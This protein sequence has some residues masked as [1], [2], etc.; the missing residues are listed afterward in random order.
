MIYISIVVPIRNEQNYILQTL[1]SLINQ[2]YPED[3]YEI[4]VVDGMSTDNTC[5]V[6]RNYINTHK[7]KNIYLL[8]NPRKLS[9]CARNTGVKTAKGRL[10]AVI[11]G[12]VFIPNNQL[13]KNMEEI[14]ESKSAYCLARP[15][16]LDVP[17][18]KS[19]TAYWIAQARKTWLG[20]SQN[21]YI[22]SDYEGFANPV[23]SG[24]AYDKSVFKKVG[25]F[26]ESFDAAE[27]VEFHFRLFMAGIEAYTSPRLL[28]Y[29]YPRESL[30]ALF[31]QQVRYGIGRAKF[32]IKHKNGFTKETPIPSLILLFLVSSPLVLLITSNI[33]VLKYIYCALIIFYLSTIFIT[34]IVEA[35]KRDNFFAGFIVGSSIMLTHLGL[36]WGFIKKFIF[37][38]G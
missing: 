28:I 18:L 30:L 13:F 9:S 17:G 27:D 12:H 35:M 31:K 33:P 22:Y 8:K 14:K 32:V 6:V 38:K 10:I 29:S 15:A 3:K 25:Y 34:G 11:D 21:S 2:E 7:E 26:D 5:R 23:S 19:G 24:F 37:R 16:P 20:H 36:G 4:I 1:D